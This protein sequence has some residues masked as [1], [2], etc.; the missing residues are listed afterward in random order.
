MGQAD[1]VA[2][3]AD[4]RE[5]PY[6]LFMLAALLLWNFFSATVSSASMSLIANAGIVRKIYFPRLIMPLSSA[7]ATLMDAT[8][9]FGLLIIL[10]AWYAMGATYFLLLI[11]LLCLSILLAALGIGLFLSAL[12][13]TYRDFKYVVP[14]LMSI[15]MYISPVFWAYEQ[16]YEYFDK[17]NLASYKWLLNINP[18]SGTINLFRRIILAQPITDQALISWAISA[19]VS[20]ICFIFGL[21]YFLRIERKFA[22]IA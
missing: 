5:I 18:V 10:M 20:I 11:P 15:W 13:V 6:P 9:T 7:G 14:F 3:L 21:M 8:I 17:N 19:T 1:R 4:G 16:A 12:S 2:Q 22:D